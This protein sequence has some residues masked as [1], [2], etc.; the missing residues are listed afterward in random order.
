MP[1]KGSKNKIAKKIIE[2]L[3]PSECFVDLFGGGGAV[4]HAAIESGKYKL[5]IFNDINPLCVDG[6]KKAINGEYN[7]EKR[8]IS[9]EEFA[10]LKCSDPYVAMCFS[11]GNNLENYCYSREVE[12]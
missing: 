8:W 5:F 11:F 10:R 7:N 3:P 4:T 1:Y 9:R 6:F 12:P 2:V